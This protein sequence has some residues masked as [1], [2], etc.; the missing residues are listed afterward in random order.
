MN[1]VTINVPLGVETALARALEHYKHF[2]PGCTLGGIETRPGT[3]GIEL[4]GGLQDLN[5]IKAKILQIAAE[6]GLGRYVR[7]K[8]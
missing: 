7:S 2:L 8:G 5:K 1:S 3:V 6:N 4:H